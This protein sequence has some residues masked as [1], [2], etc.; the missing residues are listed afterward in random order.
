MLVNCDIWYQTFIG[1]SKLLVCDR[2][3][4]LCLPPP[5][6]L[7]SAT[8]WN[9]NVTVDCVIVYAVRCLYNKHKLNMHANSKK[10]ST[11]WTITQSTDTLSFQ[12][13]TFNYNYKRHLIPL[14]TIIRTLTHILIFQQ[15]FLSYPET[16]IT[17]N[18]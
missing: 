12:R 16:H 5:L 9:V 2:P 6:P 15:H 8:G 1:L 10:H 14:V 17:I 13:S 4:P 7:V 11:A 18:Y 3:S